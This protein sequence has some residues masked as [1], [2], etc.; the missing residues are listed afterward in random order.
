M[1][2]RT[3]NNDDVTIKTP[4]EV[5][6]IRTHRITENSPK[7]QELKLSKS[8]QEELDRIVQTYNLEFYDSALWA[9][10]GVSNFL[11]VSYD[12]TFG[13]AYHLTS[14]QIP[15]YLR[16]DKKDLRRYIDYLSLVLAAFGW[17]NT[18]EED[19][20]DYYLIFSALIALTPKE[21][22]RVREE[23]A[24]TLAYQALAVINKGLL[25]VKSSYDCVQDLG[26]DST[27]FNLNVRAVRQLR[28][29]LSDYE[30]EYVSGVLYL[31]P[32]TS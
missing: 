8:I 18:I 10:Y 13:A 21:V 3:L 2:V 32:T 26:F 29:I 16:N 4:E 9:A 7:P 11:W 6:K 31:E 30:I 25:K 20:G 22:E 17:I 23:K 5:K 12:F 15:Q 1:I 19:D 27:D 28:I 24:Q 14:N